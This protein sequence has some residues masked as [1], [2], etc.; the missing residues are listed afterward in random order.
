MSI[1]APK[2]QGGKI[3]MSEAFSFLKSSYPSYD[4]LPIS[5]LAGFFFIGIVLCNAIIY[6]RR[7]ETFGAHI[8]PSQ[9]RGPH[10]PTVN[11]LRGWTPHEL[12]ISNRVLRVLLCP[13]KR[14]QIF[15]YHKSFH[16]LVW[17]GLAVNCILVTIF[18]VLISSA[19]F[20]VTSGY[21]MIGMIFLEGFAEWIEYAMSDLPAFLPSAGIQIGNPD[22]VDGEK[23][24]INTVDIKHHF[25]K[26][27]VFKINI[28]LFLY[29]PMSYFLL[30][31]AMSLIIKTS[32]Y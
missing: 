1:L 27:Q 10:E 6:S 4:V 16:E 19:S 14:Q 30:L 2:K 11:S 25:S 13:S 23:A 28:F 8:S 29:Y 15:G 17:F 12:Y 26:K 18:S 32:T 22:N 5:W 7:G 24:T 21:L 20:L 31:C 9:P 3:R